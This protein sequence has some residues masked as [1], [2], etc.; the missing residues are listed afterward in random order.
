MTPTIAVDALFK[1]MLAE[2]RADQSAFDLVPFEF[3]PHAQKG[4]YLQDLLAYS[5]STPR[6]IVAC[7][8]GDGLII[9]DDTIECIGNPSWLFRG[10]HGL[11]NPRT[12]SEVRALVTHSTHPVP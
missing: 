6:P 3:F 4:N 9:L 5:N 8:D 12:L 10:K 2:D 11:V 7:P 1:G